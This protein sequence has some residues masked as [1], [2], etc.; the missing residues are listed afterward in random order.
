MIDLRP[1]HL[2]IVKAILAEHL[3]GMEVRAFGSR[4]TRTAK[5]HSDLDLAIMGKDRINGKT[6]TRLKLA[7]E[8]SDLPFRV[9]MVDWQVISAEF[10][11]IIDANYEVLQTTS[12][13]DKFT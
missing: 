2:D 11:R 12:E 7:F 10:R 3:P 9:D 5:A 1:D 13:S 4:V 6:M 8:E